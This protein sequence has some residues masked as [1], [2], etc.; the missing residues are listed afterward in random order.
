M[1]RMRKKKSFFSLA[2]RNIFSVERVVY[3]SVWQ[4]LERQGGLR[5][6]QIN[7]LVRR[8]RSF[9]ESTLQVSIRSAALGVFL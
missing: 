9:L 3:V 4:S 8:L 2:F 1:S 6:F 5:S 7:K